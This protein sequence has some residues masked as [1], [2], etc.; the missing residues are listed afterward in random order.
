MAAVEV[1]GLTVRYGDVT[2]VDGVS[3]EAPGRADHRGARSERRRARPPPIEVLEGFRR[4]DAGRD[5]GGRARPAR[6]PRRPHP[7]GGRDAAG[8]RR[9]AGGARA[10]GAPPRRRPLR[11][12]ARSRRR[13]SSGSGSPAPSAAPGAR[14]PAASSAGWPSPWRWSGGRRS[15]SSTNPA[16]VSTRRVAQPIREVVAGA[17]RRRRH[18]ACSRPT[19]S[20]RSSG[21]PTTS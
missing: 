20:T 18:R 6:R 2:A 7:P 11:R 19:T 12:R 13:C 3:F 21:S 8:G 14:S 1:D 5:V 4:P 9:R 16:P 17:A 15:R 10:G